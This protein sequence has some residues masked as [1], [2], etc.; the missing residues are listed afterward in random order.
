MTPIFEAIGPFC[1][2][3]DIPDLPITSQNNITGSWSPVINNTAT[4]EYTFTPDAGQCA[5]PTTLTIIV[6]PV[7]EAPDAT[8]TQPTCSDATGSVTLT[9]LPSGNWTINPGSITG[10]GETVTISDLVPGTYNFTV[11]NEAGC[12]S[13]ASA[14]IVIN[15]APDAPS[16][17][18]A[19]IIQPTCTESTGSI[20]LT[21]LPDGNWTINPGSIVGSGS[22]WTIADLAPGT[23]NYTVTDEAGCVS[24]ASADIV[25]DEPACAPAITITKVAD[26]DNYTAAGDILHYTIVVT[27]TGNVTLTD[28]VVTD[29]LTALN[30]T[31]STLDP[32]QAVTI[33]TEYTI[34][35]SDLDSDEVE[36]EVTAAFEYDGQ[37]YDETATETVPSAQGPALTIAKDAVESSF[38][39]VGE[40]LHYNIVVTNTGN[41]TLINIEVNDPLT[42]LSQ[43][44]P[45]LEPGAD[46]TIATEYT[47]VQND[48][49]SGE[50]E[51]TATASFNYGGTDY[52]EEDEETV[53]STQGPAITIVKE[54]DESTYSSAGQVLHYTIVVTN[55][56]NVTLTN[57]AVTDPL[58]GM[59]ETIASIDPG[60][61]ISFSTTYTVLLSDLNGSS[62]ENTATATFNYGGT[63][64]SESDDATVASAQGPD[65]TITKDARESSFSS[66]DQVIH[67]TIIVRNTGNV[68]LTNIE[69]IDPL[70]G[71]N[72]TIS[73]L[74]PGEEET[75]TTSYTVDQRDLNRGQVE[76]TAT[77][78]FNYDGRE[79]TETVDETVTS[80]QGPDITIVKSAAESRFSST[81]DVI[82]YTIV[83]TNTG[84]VTLTNI[85]VTDPLTVFSQTIPTL[86]PGASITFHT[87]HPIVQSDLNNGRVSNTATAAYTYRGTPY[88][89][90][91]NV[92]V[93]ATQGPDLTITKSAS[94]MTYSSVGT[95]ITYTIRITNTGNVT[96]SNIQVS[97][98]VTGLS[99]TVSSLA[100]GASR[101]FTTTH[102]ITQN[103]I[104][105]GHFDNTA[106]A[107]YTYSGRPYTEQASV[108]VN[109]NQAPGL[110]ITKTA[111]ESTLLCCR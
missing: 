2:G 24:A 33:F 75:F 100:P 26:E 98:P 68:T 89:E 71:L 52:R 105:G 29:P 37:D 67:Y 104:N 45:S 83:V 54:A 82:H 92:I 3:D 61:E 51:N 46:E 109:A 78:T 70:T 40:V 43:T 90:S 77:A 36:N 17:P 88:S 69:V 23:Y 96:L 6:N 28:I 101:S 10:S 53:S 48:I 103:D 95:V 80:A 64:Y 99:E 79:Y 60:E 32:G 15:P 85:R 87:S 58:T 56:G 9:G 44:I 57:I 27:N 86:E 93:N 38:S 42:G 31:I 63:D 16:A 66:V 35:Q 39:S 1:A 30:Q 110:E 91:D 106:R 74:D 107:T 11:T 5:E 59:N 94:P 65:I 34:T 8:A 76:N 108:R 21:G 50:V 62:V 55:T 47:I 73:S 84:N 49:N 41:V 22:E 25:I 19:T 111:D 12:T 14:D 4:T 13:P 81:G 97:D 20:T 102:R 18:I 72:E 7:P